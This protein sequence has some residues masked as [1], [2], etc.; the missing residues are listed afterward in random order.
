[1]VTDGIAVSI[2]GELVDPEHATISVFDRG[3][4][5]GDG[6]F[7]ILRT[8]N[9]VAVDLTRHIA[10][11]RDTAN[12]LELAVPAALADFVAATLAAAG[13]GDHR[14]RILITRGPGALHRRLSDLGPGRAIV[15]VEPLPSQPTELAA[16]VV[17]L[18]LA[19]RHGRG[20]KTLAYLDS[21]LA[22]EMAG[23]DEAIRLDADGN[24]AEGATSNVFVVAAGVVATPPA[25]GGVLPGI[26]RG[27]VL[28]LCDRLGIATVLR[29]V[30]RR[31]L[32][33]ADEVFVT[34]SL[35]GV[36][37]VTSLD[38]ESRPHGPVTARIAHAYAACMRDASTL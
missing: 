27:R 4:L 23:G 21:V 12:E 19:R 16:V 10:R 3:L 7:E 5:Y 2:D 24:V 11:L 35:R 36:V 32:H 8:W 25:D 18:P 34:S 30:S 31:E 17:D 6:S 14:I 26:V 22:R 9:G 20:H 13:P 15:I 1:L 28:E 29:T 33:A 37:A 38:G